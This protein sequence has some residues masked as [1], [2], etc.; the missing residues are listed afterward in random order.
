MMGVQRAAVPTWW[1][2]I[3][4]LVADAIDHGS[5]ILDL[6]SVHDAIAA[7]DMQLWIAWAGPPD[8]PDIRAIAVTE[9]RNGPRA[10]VCGVFLCTGAGRENWQHHLATIEA[11]AAAAGCDGMKLLARPGWKRPLAP[12]GYRMTHVML[13]KEIHHER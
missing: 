6:Q 2:H 12:A 1:P 9:I 7:G 11:W 3:R 5:S 10:K 4:H 13:E 8:K